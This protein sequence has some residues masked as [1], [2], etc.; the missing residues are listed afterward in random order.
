MYL[1][2]IIFIWIWFFFMPQKGIRCAKNFW[3]LLMDGFEG[4]ELSGN[5]V[6]KFWKGAKANPTWILMSKKL[7]S[8]HKPYYILFSCS[9][10]A[11]IF[12]I[13]IDRNASLVNFVQPNFY[14]VEPKYVYEE[15]K[16]DILGSFLCVPFSMWQNHLL[17]P[18]ME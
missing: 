5:W 9:L 18:C 8:I 17:F 15:K 7:R 6:E 1:P 2:T 13:I 12:Q 16:W 4:I 3:L 10:P 14:F 11:T